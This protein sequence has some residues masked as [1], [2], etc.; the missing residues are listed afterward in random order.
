MRKIYTAIVNWLKYY[1]PIGLVILT[2]LLL[3]VLL[4]GGRLFAEEIETTWR[5]GDVIPI[6]SLCTSAEAAKLYLLSDDMFTLSGQLSEIEQACFIPEELTPLGEA[7]LTEWESGPHVWA[8]S[9]YS[10]WR[11]TGAEDLVG[12]T[13]VPDDVG[14]HDEAVPL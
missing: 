13:A 6:F 3:V 8:E 12:W 5:S 2:L 10:I 11:I 7:R 4:W 9:D 14:P 1:D